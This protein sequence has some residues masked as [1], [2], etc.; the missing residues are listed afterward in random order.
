MPVAAWRSADVLDLNSQQRVFELTQSLSACVSLVYRAVLWIVAMQVDWK[1]LTLGMPMQNSCLYWPSVRPGMVVICSVLWT[2]R[3]LRGRSYCWSMVW[4]TTLTIPRTTGFNGRLGTV[5]CV[6]R[7]CDPR[8]GDVAVSGS[9]HRSGLDSRELS[10]HA[11]ALHWG[12][13]PWCQH[14]GPVSL[15]RCRSCAPGPV[16][17]AAADFS[18]EASSMQDY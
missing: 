8:R 16:I 3:T 15:A 12:A 5:A 6:C 10:T 4:N 1:K 14:S 18:A 11:A 17:S 9:R 2:L 13:V 7:A